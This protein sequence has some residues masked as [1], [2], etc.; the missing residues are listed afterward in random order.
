M[1]NTR[2]L[3]RKAHTLFNVPDV[4]RRTQRHNRHQWVRSVQRLGDQWLL[5]KHIERKP[6]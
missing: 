2:E 6:S 1:P 4:P 5:A 3:V